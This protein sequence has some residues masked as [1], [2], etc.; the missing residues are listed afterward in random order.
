MH[1]AYDFDN[2]I[3]KIQNHFLN[4]VISSLN[5][6]VHSFL[7]NK[8]NFFLK[9]KY[10]VKRNV[11]YDFVEKLKKYNIKELLENLDVSPKYKRINKKF[12]QT[13]KV[14]EDNINKNNLNYLRQHPW[15][16][17]FTDKNY[18]ELFSIYYNNE[19]IIVNGKEISLTKDIKTFK[20]LLK[21]NELYKN[22]LI[23][24]AEILFLNN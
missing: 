9:F 8:K 13:K 19:P 23:E 11:N 10:S 20:D 3:R 2:N 6:V 4:F 12:E 17:E 7:N 18:L 16:N 1:T 14:K 15:F 22:K 21:S 5:K 24:T